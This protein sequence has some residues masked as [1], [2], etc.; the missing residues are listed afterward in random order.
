MEEHIGNRRLGIL[1]NE[2]YA[3]PNASELLRP[4]RRDIFRIRLGKDEAPFPGPFSSELDGDHA[5]AGEKACEGISPRAFFRSCHAGPDLLSAQ[6]AG[7]VEQVCELVI[8]PRSPARSRA[9][10]F[11]E[12]LLDRLECDV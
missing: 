8:C 11:R 12:S 9:S 6:I 10:P 4:E 3:L 1:F 5:S 7:S 2:V